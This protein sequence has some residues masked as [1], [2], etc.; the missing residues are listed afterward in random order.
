MPTPRK[1]TLLA[2]PFLLLPLL[3]TQAVGQEA[4]PS[5]PYPAS[6]LPA[7]TEPLPSGP[8]IPTSYN[9]L[10]PPPPQAPTLGPA[11]V[12]EPAAAP[13]IPTA[14]PT[15]LPPLLAEPPVTPIVAAPVADA[16]GPATPAGET[17]ITP[18]PIA[19]AAPTRWYYPSYWFG[20]APW[21]SGIEF[22]L[23]GSSGT[24]ESLS[25][26]TGG[27]V[28]RKADDY[29]FDGSLYYNKTQAE[30]VEVQSNALLDLRYDWLFDDSPWTLFVMSQT[31]YDEFQAFDFN[32]NANTG[33][34]YQWIDEDWTTLTTSVGTGAS[35]EF[36][37][38][39]DDDWVAEASF[40]FKYD[41]KWSDN[42][43]FYAKIDW[44]PEWA[45]FTNY[46]ALADVGFEF[47]LHEP[48]NMSL[49]LS[50][51]DRYDSE[52]QGAEPHNLNYS[53]MLIWK[54]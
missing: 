14:T 6:E 2:L 32:F 54:L 53:A 16:A 41:L 4:Y 44:F 37:A 45:D 18:E 7:P 9:D 35:R 21:D 27:F 42:K 1:T 15:P 40:G 51:T 29:K 8:A 52:P 33:F 20:P 36:G 50:A 24:S 23:N 26:R 31:F 39:T 43:K 48:S 5:T 30:G 38:P 10:L 46:R 34:G 11:M 12:P 3:A 28:K 49:K 17:P 22:G 47:E 19:D 25:F 13:V